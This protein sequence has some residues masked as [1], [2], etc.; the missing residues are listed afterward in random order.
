MVQTVSCDQVSLVAAKSR[1]QILW[2][3][4]STQI[5]THVSVKKLQ[6]VHATTHP[7]AT[8]KSPTRDLAPTTDDAHGDDRSVDRAAFGAMLDGE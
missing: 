1:Q 7:G 4:S 2:R 8:L 6:Q 3:L 5:Y